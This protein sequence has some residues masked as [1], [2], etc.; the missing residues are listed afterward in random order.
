MVTWDPL[1]NTHTHNWKQY[2][3][4]T[5]LAGGNKR[6]YY[7]T[8]TRA[9]SRFRMFRRKSSGISLRN[10]GVKS[11]RPSFTAS[12][13]LSP[14]KKELLLN[15]PK[16]IQLLNHL[17]IRN[18]YFHGTTG[19]LYCSHFIENRARKLLYVRFNFMLFAA[20]LQCGWAPASHTFILRVGWDEVP[21]GVD[22]NQLHVSQSDASPVL[23]QRWQQCGRCRRTTVDEHLGVCVNKKTAGFRHSC[24]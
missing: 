4:A 12:L 6:S 23:T 10:I 15:I 19:E 17:D 14:I 16:R 8:C 9:A 24:W 11:P 5:W 1:V 13:A 7:S 20:Y 3:P 2:L 22:V 18:S 21:C